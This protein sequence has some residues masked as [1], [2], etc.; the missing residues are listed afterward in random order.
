MEKIEV[1][2]LFKLIQSLD[3]SDSVR[4]TTWFSFFLTVFPQHN[5]SFKVLEPSSGWL[6]INKILPTTQSKSEK[7]LIL[8]LPC[9]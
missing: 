7:P 8:G 1:S 3:E 9:T 6:S 4:T 2:N 5:V